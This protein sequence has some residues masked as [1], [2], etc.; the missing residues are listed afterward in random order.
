MTTTATA[1]IDRTTSVENAFTD[2][3]FDV[4]GTVGMAGIPWR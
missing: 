2:A 1:A 4:H 3:G